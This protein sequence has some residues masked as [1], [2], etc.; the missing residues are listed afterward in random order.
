MILM[1]IM[2]VNGALCNAQGRINVK[3]ILDEFG[4]TARAYL[5]SANRP[6]FGI[7]SYTVPK[8]KV[9]IDIG[10][11]F[12][13]DFV[14]VPFSISYGITDK[15]EL[16][17][18]ISVYTQSYNFSGE[19]IDG[20][21]DANFGL[22]YK[23]QESDY[24]EHVFQ[25]LTKIPTADSET[26]MGTGKID[27]HFGI[28]QGYYYDKFSYDLSA[29]LNFLKR[30][31]FP[32]LGKVP[33]LLKPALDSILNQYNYEYESEMVFSFTPAYSLNE[34]F[35]MYTGLSYLRNFKLDYNMLQILGGFGYFFSEKVSVSA[36][37]SFG[38]L[39]ERSWL[40]SSGINIL[41]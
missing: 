2:F 39:N 7:S 6:S 23:F 9:S 37:A 10:A 12:N 33:K 14:E 30:R 20:M 21:G 26:Q 34:N 41:L 19:K 25:I 29:E 13:T 36:G 17:T 35:I 5:L 3:K 8:N 11:A 31:D 24:F 4:N 18:G 1:C 28:A 38:L 32:D 15:F 16:Q 40:I 27:F 22:K